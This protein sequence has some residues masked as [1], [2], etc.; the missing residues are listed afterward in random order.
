M[1]GWFYM[2]DKEKNLFLMAKKGDIDA[3]EKLIEAYHNRVYNILL[4]ASGDREEASELAQEVFIRVYRSL[5]HLQD[6]SEIPLLIYKTTKDVYFE[7]T[8]MQKASGMVIAG[9]NF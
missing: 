3:F 9:K 5:R 4:N 7:E 1:I 6:R 8:T 2:G